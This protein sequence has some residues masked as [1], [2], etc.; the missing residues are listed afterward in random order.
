MC[1]TVAF[2]LHFVEIPERFNGLNKIGRMVNKFS[3]CNP[4]QPKTLTLTPN[5]S[6]YLPENNYISIYPKTLRGA[7]HNGYDKGVDCN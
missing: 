6:N 3:E 2:I 1:S 5:K 7:F 4:F